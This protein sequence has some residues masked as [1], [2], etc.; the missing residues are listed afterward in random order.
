MN[1]VD[2][3]LAPMTPTIVPAISSRTL[4]GMFCHL[5]RLPVFASSMFETRNGNFASCD[6]RLQRTAWIVVGGLRG[7]VGSFGTE[8]ELVVADRD[9]VVTDHVV[10]AHDVGTFGEVRL[11]RALEHVAGVDEQHAATIGLARFAN[12]LDEARRA[13]ASDRPRRA[14]RSCR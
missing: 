2:S 1:G 3:V 13:A 9:R 14:D 12:V 4:D 5:M 10:R 11:E 7:D 8:V 6:A